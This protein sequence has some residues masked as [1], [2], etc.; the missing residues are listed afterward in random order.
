MSPWDKWTSVS[1]LL[2]PAQLCLSRPIVSLFRIPSGACTMINAIILAAYS[3]RKQRRPRSWKSYAR[4]N[5]SPEP[6]SVFQRPQ[7]WI[8]DVWGCVVVGWE[9]SGLSF[10]YGCESLWAEPLICTPQPLNQTVH[11]WK[12]RLHGI[13][14]TKWEG[15]TSVKW[16]RW[17]IQN[18][19]WRR[20]NIKCQCSEGKSGM[21]G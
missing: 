13:E 15:K 8:C 19:R 4:Q 12:C 18:L 9:G 3:G 14:H 11:R 20:P 1:R 2:L 6:G 21:H 5:C 7:Q 16:S 17:T 10:L